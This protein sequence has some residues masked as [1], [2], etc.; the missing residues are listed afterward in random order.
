MWYKINHNFEVI[1][2]DNNSTDNT[3]DSIKS[4]EINFQIQI[5]KTFE[6]F[7]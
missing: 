4:S 5:Y 1:I 2:I 7:W 6:L 3:W